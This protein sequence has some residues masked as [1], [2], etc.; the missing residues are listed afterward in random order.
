MNPLKQKMTMKTKNLLWAALSMTAA[1]VMTACSNDDNDMTEAPVAPSTSKTIPYTVTVGGDDAATTR[2][3][4]K[5]DPTDRELYFAS[6]DKLYI[7]GENIQGVLDLQDG[8]EGKASGATFSGELTYSGSGSPASDLS[9]TA[10]LVSE[11]QEGTNKIS[12]DATTGAVTVNYPTSAYCSSINDAVQK[13]SNLTGTS[14]YGAKAFTLTQHTAFLNFEITFED[15]TTIGTELTAVVNNNSSNICS[16]SVTTVT[17]NGVKA[18]F[19]LPVAAGTTLSSAKVTMGSKAAI[20]FGGSQTLTG[21]VYNVKK[22]IGAFQINAGGT[23]VR[24]AQGNLRYVSGAWSFFDHQYD[25]YATY[26][27]D[28]WDHFGWSS[29]NANSNY[30]VN[31]TTAIGDYTGSFVDWGSNTD[32]QNALGTGWFTLSNTEWTYLLDTRSGGTFNGNSNARYTLATINT[33]GTGVNGVILFPDNV[34]IGSSEVTT[35]GTLN[36]YSNWTTKC[37]TAQ[38]TSLEAKGCVFLPA[39]G[40]RTGGTVYNPGNRCDYWMHTDDNSSTAYQLFFIS[41][42]HAMNTDKNIYHGYLVRLVRTVT[43]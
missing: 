4:V 31:N 40:Y 1:L 26:S 32:L 2:A 10:T 17:D 27:A 12:V 3:T 42:S 37:T 41:T 7:T 13:Y 23:Q 25:Y 36:N 30:G 22:T 28:A 9:L 19:V 43:K 20:S 38:W 34:T 33:D 5:D 16:A 6:G 15:A 39:G 11:Q 21:K 18:K 24:F 35:A 29:T 8:D 14:T